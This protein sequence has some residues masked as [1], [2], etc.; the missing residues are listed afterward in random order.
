MGQIATSPGVRRR[1]RGQNKN[2]KMA[3]GLWE[4]SSFDNLADVLVSLRWIA[5]LWKVVVRRKGFL[6][7]LQY[8]LNCGRRKAYG[9]VLVKQTKQKKSYQTLARIDPKGLKMN[10]WWHVSTSGWKLPKPRLY[11]AVSSFR[12]GWISILKGQFFE[13]TLAFQRFLLVGTTVLLHY[14]SCSGWI[15]T[16]WSKWQFRYFCFQVAQ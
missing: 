12:Y 4:V 7:L 3:A 15:Y 13:T 1:G 10:G 11:Q 5:W 9:N 8:W 2:C 14:F 16:A 6:F